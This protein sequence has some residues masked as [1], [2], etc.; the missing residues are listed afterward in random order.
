MNDRKKWREI[1]RDIRAGGTTWWWWWLFII[2]NM[3]TNAQR[4]LNL[5]IKNDYIISIVLH[6]IWLFSTYIMAFRVLILFSVISR[7]SILMW[8]IDSNLFN[9]IVAFFPYS[10]S[11]V[12]SH[13]YFLIPNSRYWVFLRR[14]KKRFQ[15]KISS[16][17]KNIIS[18]CI[19]KKFSVDSHILL[20]T[21]S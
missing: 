21:N 6:H 8:N 13:I 18:D 1:V 5:T 12:S 14:I 15:I 2:R 11:S 17:W 20:Q 10:N 9:I 3:K 4:R 7:R 19:L 16:W